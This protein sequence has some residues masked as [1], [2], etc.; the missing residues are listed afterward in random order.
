MGRG[1]SLN[2]MRGMGIVEGSRM[3][4][5]VMSKEIVKDTSKVV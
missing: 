3:S 2:D 1:K 5:M 4:G